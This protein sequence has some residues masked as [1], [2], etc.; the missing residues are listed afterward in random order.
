MKKV[1]VSLHA[2]D[3]FRPEIIQDLEG[4]DY[5]HLDV[6]DGKFVSPICLNLRSFALL[7][8]NYAIPIIAHMMVINPADYIGKIIKNIDVFLFHYESKGDKDEIIEKVHKFDKKVGIALNPDTSIRKIIDILPKTEF[9]LILGV[10]P[11][12][13]GQTF[14]P[15]IQTKIDKLIEMRKNYSFQIVVDGGINENNVKNLG[16]VDIISSTSAI[17]KSS[18]P[19]KTI[20]LLKTN[21]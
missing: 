6:M 12:Y 7:K 13:S 20:Y 2:M 15:T 5:I 9:V 8:Q 17:L 11:G 21:N 14:I 19:N 1:A 4:L 18:N 16:D 3:D 10:N